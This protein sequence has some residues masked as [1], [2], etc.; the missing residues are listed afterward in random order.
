MRNVLIVL[1]ILLLAGC[2]GT[3]ETATPTPAAATPVATPVATPTATPEATPE[4]TPMPMGHDC[5]VEGYQELSDAIRIQECFMGKEEYVECVYFMLKGAREAE[6]TGETLQAGWAMRLYSKAIDCAKEAEKLPNAGLLPDKM[7]ATINN[8]F[9][10]YHADAV[11][12]A[13]IEQIDEIIAQ[14]E[15]VR[16]DFA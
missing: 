1:A 15:G 16:A 4:P 10:C 13:T 8:Y 3:E 5:Y 9:M 11:C 6:K 14:L 12:G 7:S 2:A